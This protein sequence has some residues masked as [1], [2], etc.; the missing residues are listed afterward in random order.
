[1]RYSI[2][3]NFFR[4]LKVDGFVRN[5]IGEFFSALI[6]INYL[7]KKYSEIVSVSNDNF[8]E[9]ALQTLN[10]SVILSESDLARI[11]KNG[12]AIIV[13]N[14]PF[15]G[16]EGLFVSSILQKVRKDYKIL[17][18][19]FLKIFPELENEFIFVDVFEGKD[20]LKENV[21][22]LKKAIEYVQNGGLLVIFPAGVVSHYQIHKNKITD[23]IWRTN[24]GKLINK[25]NV[26]V[27]PMFFDGQNS[28]AFQIMGII[29]PV[30]RTLR[31]PFE[32]INKQ[33]K[34]FNV[35]VGN[36][37]LPS[38]LSK[39]NS[40]DEKLDYLRRRTYNLKYRGVSISQ[41]LNDNSPIS[42]EEIQKDIPT[43]LLCDEIEKIPQNQ[44]LLKQKESLVFYSYSF[45][46]PDLLT[47]IGIE[48][49][50]T[51]R[52]VN[53]GT[54]TSIDLDKFDE[55][56]IHL[57][58][59]DSANKAIIGAY[60]LG[61]SETIIN[62]FGISGFYI[63]TLFRIKSKF[64]N[65]I[66]PSIEMGRSFISAEYQKKHNS[67][68]LLWRGIG[69]FIV[70]HPNYRFLFGPVSISNSYHPFSQKYMIEYLKTHHD[71][72]ELKSFVKPRRG[73]T[74]RLK[75]NEV[76]GKS[77][78]EIHELEEL[79]TD[80]D[81]LHDKIPILIKQYLKLGAKF[82]SFNRDEL[83]NSSL[84]GM[85]VVDLLKTDPKI[86]AKYFTNEGIILYHN[87][88]NALSKKIEL[89]H[90]EII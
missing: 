80:I 50:K 40:I 33:N 59:W 38:T 82:L 57:V 14:H 32:L 1:M 5:T 34:R 26:P 41:N 78:D 2:K 62:K 22:A 83:F 8:V 19:S 76:T 35:F 61:L 70:Q 16:I 6:G 63:T 48:R 81:P 42:N 23:P 87:Y 86:L 20:S 24:I 29:H 12:G 7:D 73:D 56:Y 72:N 69:V 89:S 75:L 28:V 84:D 18:N 49:E 43:D 46:I 65:K 47:Q 3:D 79:I 17:A 74:L 44:I 39:Y 60:R 31:L 88:H 25:L 36:E 66:S 54:G 71:D 51:F 27:F 90:T 21:K 9:Q 58:A 64:F 15:G 68:F 10:V 67:L 30:L 52:L 45:Q 13:A 77:V 53:E 55:H 4:L 11:P 37:I 85:I